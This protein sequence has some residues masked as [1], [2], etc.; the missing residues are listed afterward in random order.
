MAVT[1]VEVFAHLSDADVANLAAELDAI[2]RDVEADRGERDARYIHRTIAAQRA[3]EVTGRLLLA[4]GNRRWARWAGTATLGVAKIVENME[5]GHNVMHGQWDWMNDPEIHSTGW[6]WDMAGYAK[7]W[8][9]THNFAHHKYTNIL[10]MDD[11]VGYGLLRVTRDT[12]WQRFNLFNLFYNAMLA[13]GFEWGVGLQHLEL[14]KIFKGRSDRQESLERVREFGGK[15]GR[16]VLKDYVAFPALTSLSPG[17]TFASTVK[18]NAI[19]NVIRNLWANAIIFCGHFPDGAEKFTKTDMVGESQGQWYLRQLLGS[20]NIDAGPAMRFFS[21]SL[22]H[23]IEHH[24]FPDLPSNRY[25]EI[26]ERVRAVCERYDL[27]YTSGPFLVQY[28]KTWRTI[29]KL[30][31]PDRFLRDTADD[32]PETRSEKMF[33]ELGSDFTRV[34]PATGRRRGLKTAI[35]AVRGWRRDKRMDQAA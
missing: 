35:S 14:G 27:P 5:I 18:A 31:L 2:R 15:A 28:G 4:A 1:D 13:I 30:S 26:A 23:Q 33:A 32:A 29:A 12:P 3:L 19:A 11:D 20:A 21:G 6:E 9:F 25:P 16:Q 8:R 34:D 7:H 22:S 10:G 24:L 17:A